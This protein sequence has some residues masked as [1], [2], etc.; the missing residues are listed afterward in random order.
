M[1]KGLRAF[2]VAGAV[3]LG[4]HAWGSA[5]GWWKVV[6]PGDIIDLRGGGSG[7]SG[8]GWSGGGFRG[9]K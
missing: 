6:N 5:A 4:L 9:G 1:S 7:S 8:H 2:V 3:G